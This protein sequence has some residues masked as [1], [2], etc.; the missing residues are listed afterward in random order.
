MI[1]PIN[2]KYRITADAHCWTVQEKRNRSCKSGPREDW[3][4]ITYHGS[5]EHALGSLGERMLRVS[6]AVGLLEAQKEIKKI[7]MT[8]SQALPSVDQSLEIGGRYE[9]R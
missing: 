5:L 3:R 9:R 8:L 1:L 6:S 2:D 4:S 7:C